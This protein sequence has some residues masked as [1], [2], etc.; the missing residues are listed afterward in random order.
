MYIFFDYIFPTIPDYTSMMTGT[1]FVLFIFGSPAP[2]AI[3]N[4]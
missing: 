4:I 1:T 3:L 2:S